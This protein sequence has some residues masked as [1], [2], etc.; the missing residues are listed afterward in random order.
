MNQVLRDSRNHY[1]LERIDSLRFENRI[2]HESNRTLEAR[3]AT[4]RRWV[5][6]LGVSAGLSVAALAGLVAAGGALR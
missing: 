3:C 6:V 1:L 2:I 5:C 4:L